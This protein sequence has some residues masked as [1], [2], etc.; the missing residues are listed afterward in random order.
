MMGIAGKSLGRSAVVWVGGL[1][2]GHDPQQDALGFQS[3]LP[4]GVLS[5]GRRYSAQFS[6]HSFSGLAGLRLLI[7]YFGYLLSP[8]FVMV[9]KTSQLWKNALPQAFRRAWISAR[10]G[11]TRSAPFRVVTRAAAALAKVSISSSSCRV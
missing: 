9:Q 11:I 8:L 2:F 4:E 1:E 7:G 5:H 10:L 3:G 6:R